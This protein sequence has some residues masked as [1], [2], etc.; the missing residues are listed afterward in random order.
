MSLEIIVFAAAVAI[1]IASILAYV[2]FG[3]NAKK[4]L[5]EES[6]MATYEAFDD[7]LQT[8]LYHGSVFED[9]LSTLGCPVNPPACDKRL[10]RSSSEVD[11]TA[12]LFYFDDGT[13]NKYHTT[14]DGG[15]GQN[16]ATPEAGKQRIRDYE[17]QA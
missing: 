2:A 12:R 4:P 10:L 9:A 14:I 8:Q 13:S 7:I 6:V 16:H 11:Y 1:V 5:I 3:R 15:S 17:L